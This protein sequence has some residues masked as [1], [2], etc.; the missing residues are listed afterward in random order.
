M[1]PGRSSPRVVIVGAG[2]GGLAAALT[3]AGAGLDVTVVERDS[4]PGGK[5]RTADVG[6]EAIDCGPTVLTMRDVFE[7]LFDDAGETLSDHLRLTPADVLA[8]HAWP[9]GSKRLDLHADIERSAEAIGAFAGPAEARGYRAFCRQARTL[10]ETLDAP[11]IRNDKPDMLRLL[12]PAARAGRAFAAAPFTSFSRALEGYFADPRLR[13]LFGRYAT[14]CGS[15]PFSSPATLMLVAHVEQ[16]GVWLVEGGM[17]RLAAVIAELARAR[18]A[19]FRFG[20]HVAAIR[21]DAGRTRA[22]ELA[23]GERIAADLVICNADCAALADGLFGATVQRAAS[24]PQPGARSLSAFTY[25]FRAKAD[26]VSLA[27]HTVFFS[28]NSPAE[29]ADL[30]AGR[31]PTDPT[32]YVCAQDRG[33]TGA[34]APASG[35]ERLFC[36]VNAPAR[37]DTHTFDQS[38]IA[39]CEA[40]TF[41]ALDRCGL[42]LDRSPGPLS[43]TTP[44]DFHRRYPATGGALYGAA[45]HGWMASFRRSGVRSRIPG[46]YLCGGSVHPGPGLP[47]A[48]LSGRMAALALMA[49]CASTRR[50]RPA[51]TLGGISTA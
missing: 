24:G 23:S 43:V 17:H 14:Y 3:L 8:R 11:F 20:A 7:T 28:P 9:D 15:S 32:V 34:D 21:T 41:R 47:M 12:G 27:R 44:N 33:A 37:G 30:A 42:M 38:E 40:R 16:S 13:Q 26:G 10:F 6:G 50:F 5:L 22:V 46:L 29:F 4:L 45:S 19:T 1:P 25:A 36:I 49:D 2:M 35:P 48:A 31:L 39:Q 18:G 51:A